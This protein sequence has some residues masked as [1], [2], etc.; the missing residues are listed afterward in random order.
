MPNIQIDFILLSTAMHSIFKNNLVLPIL[1]ILSTSFISN[2]TIKTFDSTY[3]DLDYMVSSDTYVEIPNYV[4]LIND[5]TGF[6]EL[7]GFKESSGRYNRVNKFG[8]MGKYQ[9]NLNTLKMYK[10]NDASY[11]INNAKLQE[12]VFLINVQRNKWILRKDIKW[13]V[14]TVINGTKISESGI[15]AAAH[16]AGPGN[17]KKY[18]RSGGKDDKKDAFGTSISK[19]IKYFKN[20]DLSMVEAIRKPKV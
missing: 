3:I 17:V 16:L 18:L 5:Y 15:I 4:F 12:R 8:F 13:F 11:F 20:F 10:I 1:F 6:K 19:Y 14:G 9:F 2:N 7:L